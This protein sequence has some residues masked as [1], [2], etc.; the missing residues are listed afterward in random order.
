MAVLQKLA[1]TIK[2]KI[3]WLKGKFNR[4]STK[5]VPKEENKMIIGS[6][7]NFQHRGVS[8]GVDWE[9]N[10]MFIDRPPDGRPS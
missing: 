8:L 9:G 1:A 3:E 4:T 5:I 2:S 6:P 7:T 10:P